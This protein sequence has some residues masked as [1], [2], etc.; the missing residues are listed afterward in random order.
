MIVRFWYIVYDVYG[1]RCRRRVAIT[2]RH[3][4]RERIGIHNRVRSIVRKGT[5][6]RTGQRID[7]AAVSV[8]Y[9][10]TVTPRRQRS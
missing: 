6:H 8:Q 10:I 3:L 1:D 2:I 4:V 7:V 5:F 9:H